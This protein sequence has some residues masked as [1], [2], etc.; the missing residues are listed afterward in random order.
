MR[1]WIGRDGMWYFVPDSIGAN[2]VLAIDR[3]KAGNDVLFLP[4]LA[5]CIHDEMMCEVPVTAAAAAAMMA[6]P[7]TLPP[8]LPTEVVWGDKW[9]THAKW[10]SV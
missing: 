5:A 3:L 7:L 4:T 9:R 6:L 1:S 8:V 10:R 2:E